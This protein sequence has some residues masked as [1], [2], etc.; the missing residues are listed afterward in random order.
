VHSIIESWDTFAERVD[1][2]I[3]GDG[4]NLLLENVRVL[5]VGQGSKVT[6]LSELG[7]LEN[8]EELTIEEWEKWEELGAIHFARLQKLNTTA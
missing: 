6:S 5:K 8:L 2:E 1:G 4:S 7:P 3:G